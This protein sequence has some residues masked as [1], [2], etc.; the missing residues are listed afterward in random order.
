MGVLGVGV[1][2]REAAWVAHAASMVAVCGV[3]VVGEGLGGD[4]MWWKRVLTDVM[5][6][7][8]NTRIHK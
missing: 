3:V 7:Y 2:S 5:C 1:V 6:V 4:G 8:M